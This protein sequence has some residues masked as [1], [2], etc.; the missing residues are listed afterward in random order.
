MIE[1]LNARGVRTMALAVAMMVV[2][3]SCSA[4]QSSIGNLTALP[5]LS[6][7]VLRYEGQETTFLAHVV[8]NGKIENGYRGILEECDW[9]EQ[10]GSI[11]FVPKDVLEEAFEGGKR[12]SEDELQASLA[13]PQP[14]T[15]Q[16]DFAK[17]GGVEERYMRVVNNTC[18][19][20]TGRC[21]R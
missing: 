3:V 10:T 16:F 12:M 15:L 8:V 14:N 1:S 5:S 4:P 19:A 9:P 17:P 18:A 21:S 6:K 11:Y 7:D 13:R 20:V 2:S